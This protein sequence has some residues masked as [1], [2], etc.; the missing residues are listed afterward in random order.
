M[1]NE[2]FALGGPTC[3]IQQFEQLTGVRLDHFVVVDFEGF[4]GMVDAVGGVEMCIPEDI[5]DPAHHIHIEAGTR[6][7]SATRRSTTCESGTSSATA[8]TSAG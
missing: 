2:A 3:T 8:P 5:D 7:I 1:W 6:K 4:R